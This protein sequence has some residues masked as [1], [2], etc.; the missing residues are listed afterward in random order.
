L[1]SES[2]EI[3]CHSPIQSD[4]NPPRESRAS[5]RPRTFLRPNRYLSGGTL[6]Q[7]LAAGRLSVS[8]AVELLEQGAR[9]VDAAHS[10]GIAHRDLKPHNVFFDDDGRPKVPCQR[11]LREPCA[12]HSTPIASGS[13]P[14]YVMDR[15]QSGIPDR[16]D[17]CPPEMRSVLREC[18]TEGTRPNSFG[19]PFATMDPESVFPFS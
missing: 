16:F 19:V 8:V 12:S 7:R 15:S 9:G 10:L 3:P 17:D 6:A 1:N 11:L 13:S 14:G 5:E 2:S 18:S 4:R